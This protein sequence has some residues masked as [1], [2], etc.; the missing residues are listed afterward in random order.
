MSDTLRKKLENVNTNFD[1]MDQ[2]QDMFGHKSNHTRF[3]STKRYENANMAPG[4]HVRDHFIKMMN[5]FQEV[6]LYGATID[7]KTQL[8]LILN[9]L[10]PSFLT[11]ITN[12]FLNNL[13][14]DM[15]QLLNELQMF[16]VI[17]GGPSKGTENKATTNATNRYQGEA[18]LASTSK[19]KNRKERK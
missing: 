15:T 13:E 12:Y 1:I 18:N 11:F 6:E 2:L 17:N 16:E 7:E 14:Y 4:M 19:S 9:S 8:G 3:E 5:Y 10:S